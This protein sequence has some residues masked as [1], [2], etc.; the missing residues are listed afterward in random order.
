MNN[1]AVK[2]YFSLDENKR[3]LLIIEK[4]GEI[5]S[6]YPEE[7]TKPNLLDYLKA[8]LVLSPEEVIHIEK[9]IEIWKREFLTTF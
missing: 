8:R 6:I 3:D 9:K 7:L 2:V 1:C 4:N 5:G